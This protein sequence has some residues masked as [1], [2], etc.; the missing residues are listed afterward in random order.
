MGKKS[1]LKKAR[2]EDKSE[3]KIN[4]EPEISKKSLLKTYGIIAISIASYFLLTYSYNSVDRKMDKLAGA[5]TDII[6]S[7]IIDD[8]IFI[9]SYNDSFI[10][11]TECSKLPLNRLSIKSKNT[12]ELLND[13]S[14]IISYSCKEEKNNQL[15]LAGKKA[16]YKQIIFTDV[17]ESNGNTT[18]S[19]VTLDIPNEDIFIISASYHNNFENIRI[20]KQDGSITSL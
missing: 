3:N 5:N 8:K 14:K 10:G 9:L 12:K 16:D 6:S 11:I 2:N 4:S 17:I 18:S 15:I 1:K 19:D 7:K 20:V 13:S